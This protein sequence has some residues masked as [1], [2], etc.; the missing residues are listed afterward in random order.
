MEPQRIRI[1][2]VTALI[3]ALLAAQAAQTAGAFVQ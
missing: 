2:M 1:M 3:S